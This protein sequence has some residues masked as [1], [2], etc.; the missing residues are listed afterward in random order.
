MQH[1]ATF[2]GGVALGGLLA[3]AC[4]FDLYPIEETARMTLVAAQARSVDIEKKLEAHRADQRLLILSEAS[5]RGELAMARGA[6]GTARGALAT[7]R[8]ELDTMRAQNER[9]ANR[10]DDGQHQVD[11]LTDE[12]ALTRADLGR[13]GGELA[14]ARE[15]AE[16][17]R[18]DL[19]A[20]GLRFFSVP[21]PQSDRDIA[22]AFLSSD[23]TTDE[24]VA[25]VLNLRYESP[26][27]LLSLGFARRGS[28]LL[29]S[30]PRIS[31]VEGAGIVPA[32]AD[33]EEAAH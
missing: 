32:K 27:L 1:S 33:L 23:R 30:L 25:L 18:E 12:L 21:R 11:R 15:S 17:V 6:L 26:D 13:L 5:A 8:G 4:G 28:C 14:F 19:F 29:E 24:L 9:L 7:A 31:D 10:V 2:L 3:A 20:L 16:A 22:A